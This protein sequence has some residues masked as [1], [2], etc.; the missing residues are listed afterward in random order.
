MQLLEAKKT[1]PYKWVYKVKLKSDGFLE[2][3]KARFVIRGD[4]Q[5]EGIDYTETFSP[6]VKMTTIG[7]ILSIAV[8]K[9]GNFTSL[10]QITHSC[11]AI[12]TRKYT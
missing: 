3:L 1:L 4:T 5:R 12:C 6:V 9:I 11:T 10:M 8:K 7:Y 2:R